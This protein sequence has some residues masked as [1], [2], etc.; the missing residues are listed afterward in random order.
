MV[1]V[2]RVFKNSRCMIL[3]NKMHIGNIVT[4]FFINKCW[5]GAIK[6]SC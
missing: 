3:L 4:E 2:K 1:K 5:V 6:K